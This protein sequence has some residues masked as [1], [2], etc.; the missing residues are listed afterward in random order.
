MNR[1]PERLDSCLVRLGLANSRRTARALLAQ[2]RVR[3]NGRRLRKGAAVAGGDEVVVTEPFAPSVIEPNAELSIDVLYAD[4]ALLILNKPPLFPCHPLRPSDRDTVMNAVVAAFPEV[5]LV[6]DS[7]R[8]GGLVHRLDNGTSGA[9]IVARSDAALETLRA[10]IQGGAVTRQYLALA[11]GHLASPIEIGTPITHH[12]NPRKM[13]AVAPG[14]AAKG[15]R[16]AATIATPITHYDRFTLLEVRPRTGRRHQI[17]VHLASIGH[18]LAGD[19]L[20]G[21]P[22][23]EGLAPGRFWLHLSAVELESP[24]GKAIRIEAPLPGDLAWSLGALGQ[25]P[26]RRT[27]A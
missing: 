26:I 18:P 19:A 22:P 4:S 9:L 11:A 12:R 16:P 24:A 13:I 15:S 1:P 7:P 2:G 21:G 6:G 20:Y 25:K 23:L 8:E 3:V 10:A 27:P 14:S 5:A 17:R